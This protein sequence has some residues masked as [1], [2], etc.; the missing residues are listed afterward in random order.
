MLASKNLLSHAAPDL[1][2]KDQSQRTL[3]AFPLLPCSHFASVDASSGCSAP[4]ASRVTPV[5]RLTDCHQ[6]SSYSPH[7]LPLALTSIFRQPVAGR[8]PC[9]VQAGEIQHI[10]YTPVN[11][12]AEIDLSRS[13]KIS[14][15]DYNEDGAS[16]RSRYTGVSA[17]GARV[18]MCVEISHAMVND[19]SLQTV[20]DEFAAAYGIRSK[21]TLG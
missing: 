10:G 17:D 8:P 20:L 7:Y 18:P 19:G 14:V 13:A 2:A 3:S 5:P 6:S 4:W 16:P 1:A 12:A 15:P 21:T 9:R 11:G